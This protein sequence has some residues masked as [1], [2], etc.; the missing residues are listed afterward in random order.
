MLRRNS[1]LTIFFITLGMLDVFA[2]D[3]KSAGVVIDDVRSVTYISIRVDIRSSENNICLAYAGLTEDGTEI[4][5]YNSIH[6]ETD[7]GKG[8]KNV[9]YKW[10][11]IKLGYLPS[12]LIKVKT[13]SSS[14]RHK[15]VIQ[16]N[17]SL[18]L[19]TRGQKLRVIID[20]WTDEESMRVGKPSIP[21]I[22]D[23]FRCP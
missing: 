14:C 23:S 17:K 22:S 15:F 20:T 13:L 1:F 12:H 7:T 10:P 3:V 11:E 16:F 9:A 2:G 4:L 19:V 21:L 6:L 8:W 18:Y 5:Y